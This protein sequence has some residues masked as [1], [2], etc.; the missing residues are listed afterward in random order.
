MCCK[1]FKHGIEK[2]INRGQKLN[3][4]CLKLFA[5]ISDSKRLSGVYFEIG[6][7]EH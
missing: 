4:H 7:I 2:Q 3:Y 6:T 5:E 1:Y